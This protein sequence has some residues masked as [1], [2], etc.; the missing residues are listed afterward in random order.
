MLLFNSLAD[1]LLNT[2]ADV[3]LN[4]PRHRVVLGANLTPNLTD[5]KINFTGQNKTGGW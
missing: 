4:D 5:L 2:A 1:V 3:L